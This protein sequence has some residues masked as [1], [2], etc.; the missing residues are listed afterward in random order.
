MR[1]RSASPVQGPPSPRWERTAGDGQELED[2]AFR[3]RHAIDLAQDGT[4][5]GRRRRPPGRE[6]LDQQG[7]AAGELDH[8]L[9]ARACDVGLDAPGQGQRVLIGQPGDPDDEP[10][11]IAQQ[12]DGRRT[13]GVPFANAGDDEDPIDEHPDDIAR[14][15]SVHCRSSTNSRSGPI[16]RS[17]CAATDAGSPVTGR[18]IARRIAR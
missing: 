13:A 14:R 11:A 9:E 10:A 18:P 5:Q 12:I 4:L 6:L 2:V 1:S 3:R 8:P 16:S 15:G 7:V 17:V